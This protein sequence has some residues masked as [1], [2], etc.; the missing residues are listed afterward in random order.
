VDGRADGDVHR[1]CPIM[2]CS[3]IGSAGLCPWRN[4]G[5]PL[6]N[7]DGCPRDGAQA[8]FDA[9]ILAA[10]LDLSSR[11]YRRLAVARRLKA[12]DDIHIYDI[13]GGQSNARFTFEGGDEQSPRMVSRM[14]HTVAVWCTARLAGSDFTT[15]RPPIG[16]GTPGTIDQGRACPLSQGVF[17]PDGKFLIFSDTGSSHEERSLDAAC[18]VSWRPAQTQAKQWIRTPFSRGLSRVFLRWPVRPPTSPTT[19]AK[20]RSSS[21]SSPTLEA[22]RQILDLGRQ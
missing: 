12:N 3:P 6:P 5:R 11:W 2:R 13:A 19:R 7:R 14:E 15:G 16:G 18:S 21:C 9:R 1:R 8:P 17:Q 4:V 10:E 22:R 20:R